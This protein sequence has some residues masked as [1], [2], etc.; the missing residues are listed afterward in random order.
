MNDAPAGFPPLLE[1]ALRFAAAAHA[2]QTRKSTGVPYLT[3]PAA[4]ALLLARH[5]WTDDATLAAALL[6]DTVEDT[7]AT[8]A[9]IAAAFPPP[10]PEHV[11]ALSERK[12]DAAGEPIPWADRKSEHLTRLAAAPVAV[13]AV[14]LA[15]KLHN[16]GTV[17]HD[18]AAGEP[19][20][21]RFNAPR[22]TILEHAAT[23]VDRVAGNEPRLASLAGAVRGELTCLS[24]EASS[25]P[26]I[27]PAGM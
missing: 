8:A 1:D 15:D 27:G 11:A 12:R 22:E 16:L 20:W 26:A 21:E 2:G 23:F 3:H 25:S 18:L 9:Q 10:V 19:V 4:V 14:A 13:R 17:R 24:R 5:G 7:A 6:H